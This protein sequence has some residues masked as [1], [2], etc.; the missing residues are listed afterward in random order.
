MPP[1]CRREIASQVTAGV[2]LVKK[3]ENVRALVNALSETLPD[4]YSALV[5]ERD[6]H[7]RLRRKVL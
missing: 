2:E 5:D 3:R 1:R 7:V 6:E 4:I